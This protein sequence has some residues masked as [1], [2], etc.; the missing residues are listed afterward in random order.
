MGARFF[1][2]FSP[3]HGRNDKHQEWKSKIVC[4]VVMLDGLIA[5]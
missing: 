3:P 1:V 4:Q 5:K 2:A